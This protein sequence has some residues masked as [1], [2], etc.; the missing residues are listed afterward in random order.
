MK[1]RKFDRKGKTFEKMF[2]DL[3]N[4]KANEFVERRYLNIPNDV[5]RGGI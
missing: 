5:E 2:F 3:V 1:T 4:T